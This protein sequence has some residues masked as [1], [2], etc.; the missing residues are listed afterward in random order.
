MG[1]LLIRDRDAGNLVIPKQVAIV[2]L[3]DLIIHIEQ[4]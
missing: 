1:I 3:L 2:W 4:Q